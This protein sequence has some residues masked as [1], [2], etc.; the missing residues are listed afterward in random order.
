M[1]ACPPRLIRNMVER[2][3]RR[4]LS[5]ADEAQVRAALTAER[6]EATARL[7][8]LAA[9]F[10]GLIEASRA[11]ANDDEHDPEGA[12]IA[13]ER[14]QVATFAEQARTR[15]ADLDL[16][17]AR[18][19]SGTYGICEN[20]GGGIGVERLIARPSARTCI[21]CAAAAR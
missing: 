21:G 6:A 3:E 13:F 2:G 12:T 10:E 16:A 7:D 1:A 4:G 19:D 8:S 14:S 15:V 5:G 11:I 18:L 9:D 20:C 17:L